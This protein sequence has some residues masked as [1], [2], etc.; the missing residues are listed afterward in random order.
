[1]REHKM[2]RMSRIVV[3]L[4]A[5]CLPALAACGGSDDSSSANADCPVEDLANA[6]GK[7]EITFWYTQGGDNARELERIIKQFND[8]NPKV[9]VKGVAFPTYPDLLNKYEA[10]LTT[11]DQPD[12]GHFEETT[13]QRLVDSNSMVPMQACVDAADYDLSD[14]LPKAISYY[15]VDGK[16][17][18]MPWHVSN[19]ILYFNAQAFQKAGL[20]PAKPPATLA[21]VKDYAQKLVASGVVKHG[22]ALPDQPFYNEFWY[23][24][25]GQEYVNNGNGRRD[26]ATKANL[27]NETGI[28]VW[29][30]WRDMVKS[31]LALDTGDASTA[32]HLLAIGTGDAAMA[33]DGSTALGPVNAVL[34]TGQYPNVTLGAGP[35]PGL[36]TGG[37]A[38][39][40][41]G[42]LWI[43]KKASAIRRAAAWE[44]VKFMSTPEMTAEWSAISGSVPIRVSSTKLPRIQELWA[45]QPAYKISYDQL[46]AGPNDDSTVGSLIGPYQEVRNAV[47]DGLAS[48]NTSNISP[49]D[50]L[51]TAQARADKAIAD[52]NARVGK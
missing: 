48:L 49:A 18:S 29:S 42:S 43:P 20:D 44:F 24:K 14:F 41:D 40:G 38:P 11:G 3:L 2:P 32:N 17:R 19:P 26:R 46:E 52:Y 9:T 23:A 39:V 5:L 22:I 7:T 16:L 27:D 37:G 31:G 13:V 35:F 25:D 50:A 36:R 8:S 4:A 34:G 51:K 12:L 15:T 1:M 10:G 30:W 6:P 33:I 45:K 21:E 47:R 28:A